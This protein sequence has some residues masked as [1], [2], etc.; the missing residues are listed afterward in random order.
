M[1]HVKH[2]IGPSQR[3]ICGTQSRDDELPAK[4]SHRSEQSLSVGGVQFRGWVIQ[5]Q[6]GGPAGHLGNVACHAQGHRCTQDL[7]LAS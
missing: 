4:T 2:R 6:G 3:G 7:L 5:Q 1:F